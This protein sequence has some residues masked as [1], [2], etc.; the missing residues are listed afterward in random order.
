MI[1]ATHWWSSLNLTTTLYSHSYSGVCDCPGASWAHSPGFCQQLPLQY[2]Q[3]QLGILQGHL[4]VD[5]GPG[6]VA[7]YF[8]ML[9]IG[10]GS[11]PGQVEATTFIATHKN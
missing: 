8:Q 3:D 9:Q 6:N 11:K 10:Q 1:H 7:E 2:H 4:I 5:R